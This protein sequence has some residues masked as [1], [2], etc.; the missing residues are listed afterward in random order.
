MEAVVDAQVKKKTKKKK[1]PASA[2]TT[3]DKKKVSA[4]KKKK[5]T[6]TAAATT[7]S[8]PS[9]IQEDPSKESEYEEEVTAPSIAEEKS[10]SRT[11]KRRKKSKTVTPPP[12]KKKKNA[13]GTSTAA[14]SKSKGVTSAATDVT[15]SGGDDEDGDGDVNN[16]SAAQQTTATSNR[17]T[18]Q[19]IADE[20]QQLSSRQSRMKKRPQKQNQQQ[21]SVSEQIKRGRGHVSLSPTRQQRRKDGKIIKNSN[22]RSIVDDKKSTRRKG[23][24]KSTD[25]IT[26]AVVVAGAHAVAGRSEDEE[27]DDENSNDDNDN[28]GSDEDDSDDSSTTEP[29]AVAIEGMNSNSNIS[30]TYNDTIEANRDV[31]D[32]NNNVGRVSESDLMVEA[33][34][35]EE[36]QN[37]GMTQDERKAIEL[38]TR[39]QVMDEMNENVAQAEVVV[40]GDSNNRRQA[41][42]LT[43]CCCC[44]V[45]IVS[46]ILGSVLGARNNRKDSN[47][48]STQ[49]PSM[50]PTMIPLNNSFCEEAIPVG[51]GGSS[52]ET[53]IFGSLAGVYKSQNVLR[54]EAFDNQWLD[55][56]VGLWYK[57]VASNDGPVSARIFAEGDTELQVYVDV[58]NINDCFGTCIDN[59][60]YYGFGDEVAWP[61]VS[62][63]EY[64][65]LIH[66]G[67]HWGQ[68][69]D[70]RPLD[71]ELT[72]DDNDDCENAFGPLPPSGFHVG[73][74]ASDASTNSQFV[75]KCTNSESS[76]TMPGVWYIVSGNGAVI[77]ASTC[78]ATSMDTR[79]YVFRGVTCDRLE[80]VDWSDDAC[81]KQSLVAWSSMENTS[82]YVLVTGPADTGG[83]FS[84]EFQTENLTPTIQN[85]DFC[86]N[87]PNIDV[88]ANG[89]RPILLDFSVATEDPDVNDNRCY[90]YPDPDDVPI[91]IWFTI[92]GTGQE[93]A[94]ALESES[95]EDLCGTFLSLYTG[96]SCTDLS[97]LFSCTE[98][99]RW[100]TEVGELYYVFVNYFGDLFAPSSPISLLVSQQ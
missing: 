33:E 76:S 14:K 17:D 1:K 22:N 20:K 48:D 21:R 74:I 29:G 63:E 62:G 95:I 55:E 85:G 66:T 90:F 13:G 82:Y 79:I 26:P 30:I 91:G 52:N 59:T 96:S 46:I 68:N 77:S 50:S 27:D 35:V 60:F 49:S 97:C 47:E 99:C 16:S 41:V 32:T 8:L 92:T 86:L 23:R 12:T 15:P 37:N 45:I 19:R 83:S 93:M 98:D 100:Q 78:T 44:L 88:V 6:K 39:R 38:E 61:T 18:T 69:K 72:F 56:G 67:V 10:R 75:D 54:C 5:K 28:A 53:S 65:I 64:Y 43:V 36:G 70:T 42:I 40:G 89:G 81:G 3:E 9:G 34:L 4:I 57:Y 7:T 51:L 73:S 2:A 31:G 58:N 80:C 71:F 24:K 87:A 25:N 11:G 94:I 84:L